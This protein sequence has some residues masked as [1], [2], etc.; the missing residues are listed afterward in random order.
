MRTTAIFSYKGGTG[1]TT[2]AINLAAELAAHGKRV[3]LIDADGQR[4]TS[5]FFDVDTENA[6]TLYELLEGSEPYYENLLQYQCGDIP[7]MMNIAVLPSSAKL[8][9]VELERTMGEATSL[10]LG[11]IRDL[12]EAVAEDDAADF[13]L[14]DCPP[15]FAPQTVAALIAADDVIVPVTPDS[16]SVSGL[17]DVGISIQGARKSNHRLRIAGVLMTKVD[18]SAIARDAEAGLRQSGYPVFKTTIRQSVWPS[19]TSYEHKPLRVCAYW[20][21]IF[22]DYKALCEEYLRGGAGNG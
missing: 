6:A 15:S 20:T 11:A 19:K 17:R 14:I 8:A 9:T 22:R 7:K 3:I 18:I 5:D 10:H 21:A 1:K 12:C 2:T 13:V 4:N 16:W